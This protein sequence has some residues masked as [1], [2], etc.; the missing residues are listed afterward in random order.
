MLEQLD[1]RNLALIEDIH[2]DFTCGF[3]IL[4]GETGAGKSIILGAL[5]LLLGEKADG[6]VVRTGSEEASVSAILSVGAAHPIRAWLAERDVEPD[7]DEILVRRTVKSSGRGS[8]NVQGTP[9]TRSDLAYIGDAMFDMHGQHEHQSLL[10]SD[11]QRRVLDSYGS[12]DG[13]VDSYAQR[14]R[15]LEETKRHLELLEQELA[16]ASREEDYLRFVAEELQR[17]RLESDEDVRL[18][19]EIS[20]LS[21]FE[22]IRENLETVHAFL[23]GSVGEGALFALSQALQGSKRAAKADQSLD[24]MSERIES[25]LLDIQDVAQTVRDR[26]SSMSFS[27]DRL[28]EL[29]ARLALIQRLKKK[30]GPTLEAVLEFQNQTEAKLE[31]TKAG[32][33]RS[34][35]LRREIADKESHVRRAADE[36]TR[37]RNDAARRL[38]TLVAQRLSHLGM[39]HVVFTI[40]IEPRERSIHGADHIDFLFS[41]NLGEPL[42]SLRE[43]ASGGELSRVMLAV[44]TVLAESDDVETLVF[45]EVDAGIGGSVA[46]AVGDQMAELSKSRQVI[47]ITHLASIAA[48][49]DHHMVVRK[50]TDSGRTYTRIAEVKDSE[51]VSELARM[52]GGKSGDAAALAHASTLLG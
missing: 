26:L 33:D 38:E 19:E 12:L 30:Y 42:R 4:T 37:S 23:K 15:E 52:L 14:Y 34:Q 22:T 20:V 10:H 2:I 6:S 31:A 5:E 48:K 45:D 39:P 32:D 43:I 36:L 3:N 1:I 11:R 27:Q 8:I 51:R 16:Q 25:A 41:A 50:E 17:A 47:A 46:L 9:M 40:A 21:Q 7:G 29:H 24:Q 35:E 44:K 28:D 49:A 13:L 18:Q